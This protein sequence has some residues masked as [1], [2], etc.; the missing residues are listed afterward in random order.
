MAIQKQVTSKASFPPKKVLNYGEVVEYL[1]AHWHIN[2][3]NKTLARV[4]ELDAALGHPSKKINALLV[5]GSNGKSVTIGL[6]AKLLREEGI[7]VGT[8]MSPHLLTYNERLMTNLEAIANQQFAEIGSEVIHTAESKNIQAHSH[9]LLTMMALLYFVENE[10]DVALFEV[11]E[12]GAY[13]PTNICTALVA[14]PLRILS[15]T[16]HRFKPQG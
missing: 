9:E 1:N 10:V 11:A 12:G 3:T 14:A 4:K 13:D 5:A 15:A 2:T 6:T 8:F 16:T 7:K